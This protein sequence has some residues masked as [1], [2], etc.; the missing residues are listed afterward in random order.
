MYY[1]P[2]S[3]EI[4][5]KREALGISQSEAAT[6]CLVQLNTWARWEQGN[7]KMPP[8]VWELMQYKALEL[9]HNIGSEP[10]N[11]QA[12]TVLNEMLHGWK[13]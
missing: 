13:D 9:Q 2:T 11:Q 12:A 5:Q 3:K 1:Q 10:N 4:R 7:R 6:M 8:P